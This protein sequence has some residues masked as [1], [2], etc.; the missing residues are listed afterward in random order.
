MASRGSERRSRRAVAGSRHGARGR[1]ARG[2]G[3]DG[4]GRFAEAGANDDQDL[5]EARAR[6]DAAE[7][8][9]A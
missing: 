2:V 3:R 8:E 4:V 9:K 6:I 1:A 7:K 5:G